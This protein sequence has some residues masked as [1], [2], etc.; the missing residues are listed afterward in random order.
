LAVGCANFGE[1][2][3]QPGGLA[4]FS[5]EAAFAHL[6]QLVALGP[7]VAGT[8]AAGEARSY[9]R[10]TLEALGWTVHEESFHW[11][12]KPEVPERVLVNLWAELPGGRSGRIA[13]ATPLDT[14]PLAGV[15]ANE[16]GSGAALLLELARVLAAR[17][18]PY[19]VR[20]LFLDGELL[21][22]ETPFLGSEHAFL[23]LEE[24]A[25][26][27]DLYALV[28]VHQVGDRDL[29][30]RRDRS[31]DRVLRDPFFAAARRAGVAAAFPSDAPFDDVQLGHDVFVAHR[32]PRVVALADL[33][34]GGPD[35]P[36]PLW[37]TP[38]DDL[39]ACA[40]ESFEAVGRVVADGLRALAARQVVVDE[41]RG[42]AQ[43]SEDGHP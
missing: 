25:V 36:G 13:V 35:L 42:A 10:A 39:S 3:E 9:V 31:S 5:G 12:P 16:G 6:E 23:T 38:E 26:L 4:D 32:F 21:D 11:T 41:A 1:E 22:V 29:E 20:L 24:A 14:N 43:A 15:G 33:R 30:I 27:D 17:P 28:Y 7:R 40:P 18:L 19:S 34:Y 2:P 8:P 37:R